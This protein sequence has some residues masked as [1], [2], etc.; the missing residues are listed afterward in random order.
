MVQNFAWFS[1]EVVE[2]YVTSVATHWAREVELSKN[3]ANRLVDQRNTLTSALEK[4]QAKLDALQ[5]KFISFQ[6]ELLKEKNNTI[7]KLVG[8]VQATVKDELKSYASVV[9]S[10]CSASLA[11]ARLQ[12]AMKKVT[13]EED[14]SCCNVSDPAH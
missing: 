10:S 2:P 13:T 9:K 7:V 11:P 8:S 12:A 4:A 5:E 1:Y 14:R 6:D 3:F